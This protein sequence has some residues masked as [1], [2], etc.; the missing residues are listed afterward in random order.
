MENLL[1]LTAANGHSPS[2][3]SSVRWLQRKC[4]CGECAE[5]RKKRAVQSRSNSRNEPNSVPPIVHDVLRSPGHPLD[6][7]ARGFFESRFGHDFSKVRIHADGPAAESSKAVAASAYTVGPH[8]VFAAGQ[9][10]PGTSAGMRLLAHELA[11]VIQQGT[12][13]LGASVAI[14]PLDHPFEREADA[15]A[16]HVVSGKT[17]MRASAPACSGSPR[18]A[19]RSKPMIAPDGRS[20]RSASAFTW[21]AMLHPRRSIRS[22]PTM[23]RCRCASHPVPAGRIRLTARCRSRTARQSL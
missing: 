16:D 23:G 2:G 21:H 5:C 6:A 22:W 15:A 13:S 18:R 12:P 8:I 7:G 19:A 4:A 10:A 14:G 9:Y 11:H 3:S 17:A 1:T 20:I